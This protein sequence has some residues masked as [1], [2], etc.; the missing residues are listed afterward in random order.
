M[1]LPFDLCLRAM[2]RCLRAVGR[3]RDNAEADTDH[4][5]AAPLGASAKER[6]MR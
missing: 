5:R 4:H 3:Q 1:R 2:D 6:L